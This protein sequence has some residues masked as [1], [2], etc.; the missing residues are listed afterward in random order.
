MIQ[1]FK[2]NKVCSHLT[3]KLFRPTLL[4]RNTL[5]PLPTVTNIKCVEV[6]CD[7]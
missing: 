1:Q 2:A 4:S 3:A 7:N 6:S 5:N